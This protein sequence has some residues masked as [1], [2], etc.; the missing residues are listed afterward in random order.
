MPESIPL[1]CLSCRVESP[2][3]IRDVRAINGHGYVECPAC[4]YFN[5][6]DD[7]KEALNG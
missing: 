2:V 4:H 6:F 3:T 7:I 5:Y 1:S